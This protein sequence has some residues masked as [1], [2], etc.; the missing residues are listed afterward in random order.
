MAKRRRLSG[1]PLLVAAAG[2]ALTVGCGK[3]AE[4][5]PTLCVKVVPDDAA[6]EIRI[7]GAPA[8]P[9]GCAPMSEGS[10]REVHV[11]AEG[12]D[13]VEVQV[14]E[15]LDV[16]V[17]DLVPPP[18]EPPVGNLMPPPDLEIEEPEPPPPPPPPV[19]PPPKTMPPVPPPV[20]NLMPPPE[21]M[22]K[23]EPSGGEP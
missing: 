21:R 13:T 20:G 10:K 8:G 19:R 5:E 1:K 22:P 4:P 14:P 9:D 6:A 2:A 11:E 23:L 7:D 17:V 3:P 18:P 12:Y 16:I 15:G